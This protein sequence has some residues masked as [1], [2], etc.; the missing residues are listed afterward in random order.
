MLRKQKI[1]EVQNRMLKEMEADSEGRLF[2]V[3]AH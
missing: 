1:E 2:E 3:V